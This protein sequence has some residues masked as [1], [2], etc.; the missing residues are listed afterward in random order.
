MDLLIISNYWH[1]PSEK[2]S[3]RYHSIATMA[4]ENGF[5]VEVLTS[6]FYHTKKKQRDI[7][8]KYDCNY[9]Y[10]LIAEPAYKKNISIKR[11]IGHHC[12]KNNVISYLKKRKKPDV[13]YL[14]V[15]PTELGKAV[16]KY[17][18]KHNI[19]IIIDILDL[20]PEA[21]NMVIPKPL[22]FMLYPMKKQAE[23]VYKNANYI[24][25][26]SENYLNRAKRHNISNGN[27][28]AVYIGIDLNVF[29]NI[30]KKVAIKPNKNKKIKLV[31]I[32]MLGHSYDLISVMDAIEELQ[33]TGFNDLEFVVMGDGPLK[34]KFEKYAMSKSLPVIFKGRLS[35]EEMINELISCDI[36][37]NVLNKQAAQS[38]INKHA[39]YLA[40]GLPIINVQ[41]DME[42]NNL[43]ASYNAGIGYCNCCIADLA[44]TIKTLSNDEQLRNEMKLNSRKLAEEK[45]NRNFTYQAIIDLI[46]ETNYENTSININNESRGLQLTE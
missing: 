30:A 37:I 9:K 22:S 38:I 45:F 7:N 33:K 19:K 1:F 26:V 23:Y 32:G 4:V 35:Y 25:A 44:N 3:S 29:D 28:K 21:F 18:K 20:W 16:V 27:C 39:D 40:A 31:Y 36:A 17:A 10:T 24:V 5:N 8:N 13:I 14:F 43:L 46:T 6:S 41:P 2:T 42:F 15:P 34:E 12:F 11:L